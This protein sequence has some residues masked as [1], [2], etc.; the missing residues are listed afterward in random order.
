MMDNTGGIGGMLGTIVEAPA[1]TA[2]PLREQLNEVNVALR[3]ALVTLENIKIAIH[4]NEPPKDEVVDPELPGSMALIA[5]ELRVKSI[6][7]RNELNELFG[8]F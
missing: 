7:L 6:R 2:Q 3:D 1:P 5:G 8:T 4:G